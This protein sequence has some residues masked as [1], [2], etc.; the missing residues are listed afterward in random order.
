MVSLAVDLT[1]LK[2]GLCISSKRC[3]VSSMVYVA[4]S[5]GNIIGPHL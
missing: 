5:M 3:T 4:Y 1:K 2:H